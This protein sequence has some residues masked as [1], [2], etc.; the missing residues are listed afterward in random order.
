MLAFKTTRIDAQRESEIAY[1]AE[2]WRVPAFE[3]RRAI[4]RVGPLLADVERCVK[5]WRPNRPNGDPSRH[6]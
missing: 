4:D 5:S 2:Q 1:F 6:R 3:I